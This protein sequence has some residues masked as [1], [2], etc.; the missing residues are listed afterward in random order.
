MKQKNTITERK[1]LLVMV[2]LGFVIARGN[3]FL[4]NNKKIAS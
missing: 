2:F 3:K 1:D 4:E